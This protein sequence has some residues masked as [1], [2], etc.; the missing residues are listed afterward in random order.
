MIR[1]ELAPVAAIAGYVLKW[2]KSK[3][4]WNELI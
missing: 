2:M 3:T 4:A 1:P